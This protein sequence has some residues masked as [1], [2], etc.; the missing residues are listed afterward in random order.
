MSPLPSR[1]VQAGRLDALKG[2]LKVIVST[3]PTRM[4]TRSSVMV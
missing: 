3:M 4:T 1:Q 2:M